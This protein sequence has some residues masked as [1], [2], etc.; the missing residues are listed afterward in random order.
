MITFYTEEDLVSFGQYLLSESRNNSIENKENLNKVHQEDIANFI[1]L[2]EK[3]IE[4]QSEYFKNA[5]EHFRKQ[6]EIESVNFQQDILK[7]LLNK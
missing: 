6:F 7:Q 3:I 4:N 5:A 1:S 2:D